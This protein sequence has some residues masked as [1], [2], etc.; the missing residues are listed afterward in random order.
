MELESSKTLGLSKRHSYQKTRGHAA[1]G[2]GKNISERRGGEKSAGES[3]WV[4]V[5][6][7]VIRQGKR[8]GRWIKTRSPFVHILFKKNG[9]DK[10]GRS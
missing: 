3:A 9:S 10:N 1:E 7:E 6:D 4:W 8:K 2:E 5:E